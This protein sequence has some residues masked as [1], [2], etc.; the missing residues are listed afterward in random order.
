NTLQ[1]LSLKAFRNALPEDMF[2][3]R[4]EC[5]EDKGIDTTIE[6]KEDG[7]FLNC[8]ADVQLKG[9]DDGPERLNKD[10]SY[11]LSVASA[12]LNYRLN[13]RSPLYVVWFSQ[14]DQLR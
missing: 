11:S 9:T 8:K 13:G 5:V 3:F 2:Q 1:Q 10:G 12:N 6:A 14:L 4:D 7:Q